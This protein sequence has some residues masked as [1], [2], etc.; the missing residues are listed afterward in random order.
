MHT[1]AHP[2]IRPVLPGDLPFLKAVIE[3]NGLFPPELLDGMTAGYFA[4]NNDTGHWITCLAGQPVAVAWFAPE[5]MTSGTY[6]LYLIAVDVRHQGTGIG[7]RLMTYIEQFLRQ[8]GDRILIVETSGFPAFGRTR[9]FYLRCGYTQEA[10]IREFYAPGE[11]K[12]VFWKSLPA[13]G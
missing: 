2:D 4:E 10:R 6:N 5:P 3:S 1:S 9:A 11:D 8:R 7:A 12:I 13:P